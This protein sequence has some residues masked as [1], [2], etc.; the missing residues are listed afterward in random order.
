MRIRTHIRAGSACDLWSTNCK[1]VD[2]ATGKVFWNNC[3]HGMPMAG[4]ACMIAGLRY[5]APQ[6]NKC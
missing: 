2:Q 6:C 3:H 1:G 4:D 5:S